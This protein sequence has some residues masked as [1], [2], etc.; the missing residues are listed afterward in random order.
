M[1][2]T[3]R[4][5]MTIFVTVVM[6]TG[7]MLGVYYYNSFK[8]QDNEVA[9]IVN[10]GNAYMQG[11]CYDEAIECYEHALEY[12]EGNEQLLMAIVEAYM[13]KA[14][15]LGESDDAIISY[16]NAISYNSNNK[17]AYWSIAQIY[18]NRGEQDAMMDILRE[19]YTNTGDA[20]MESK[21]S[22]IEEERAR[23]Q[24][25][26]EAELAQELERQQEEQEKAAKLEPL[27]VL[28]EEE[29][30]D[31]LKDILRTEEYVDFSDEVIGDTS[32]YF[33]NYDENG[34]RTGTGIAVYENG[35]YY[36]GDFEDDVRSG[37]GVYMRASYSESSSIGSFIFDGAWADDKPNGD[38]VATSN[39]YKDRISANDFS[40]KEISGNYT[41]GLENGQMTLTGKTKS[42]ASRT[43]KYKAVE[44]VAEKSSNEDSGIK[45]QYIIAQTDEDNLT[46]DGSVRGVEGFVEEE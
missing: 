23:I 39:Y 4:L 12:E 33:G 2:K 29:N 20:A 16:M 15:K 32:Y 21:V 46:S 6:V 26:I 9:D 30:Y 31:G 18:E 5:I 28:F 35:Y 13:Q 22:A 17:T 7:L 14:N 19:G 44:G 10:K 41:D 45:G 37:H 27:M 43:Y 3:V 40:T 25:E 34:H 38:G 11:E 24:A 36:Y 1:N 8:S 42:G